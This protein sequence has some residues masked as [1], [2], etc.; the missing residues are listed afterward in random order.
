MAEKLN[1][2][3]N[4]LPSKSRIKVA[5]ILNTHLATLADLKSHCQQ[6]HWNV[7]GG[8]FYSLHKLFEE[9]YGLVDAHIDDV[10]ERITALG[11]TAS[12]TVRMAAAATKLKEFP[13][14]P[15]SDSGAIIALAGSF[16]QTAKAV[17]KSV[18]DTDKLG[19]AGTADLLT[20]V[21]RDLDKGLWLLE[22]HEA[23]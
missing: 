4:D 15:K 6:A 5:A 9:L 17:R 11:G 13:K 16:A 22:A 12:G 2:T 14:K 7:R 19:D 23:K 3:K 20:A 18:D 8:M 21:S 1:S 10:A